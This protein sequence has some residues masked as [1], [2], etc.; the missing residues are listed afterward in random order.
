MEPRERAIP[1]AGEAGCPFIHLVDDKWGYHTLG[2]CTGL[3]HGL[4]M[5]PTVEEYR[6]RCCTS[7]HVLC[8]VY[9]SHSGQDNL[10]AWLRAEHD[11]WALR[12]L[13]GPCAGAPI[14]PLGALSAP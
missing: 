9:R 8:P 3:P 10:E 4:L 13:R 2:A 12:P 1:D 11:P 6:S 14:A 7:A 5:I